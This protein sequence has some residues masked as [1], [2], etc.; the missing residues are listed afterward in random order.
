M[1]KAKNMNNRGGKLSNNNCLTVGYLVF[2]TFYNSD[3]HK[4]FVIEAIRE[5]GGMRRRRRRERQRQV[6]RVKHVEGQRQR[7]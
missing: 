4:I 3:F 5:R 1:S 2:L 6:D 7:L